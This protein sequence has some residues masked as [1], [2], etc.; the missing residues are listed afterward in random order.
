MTPFPYSMC[1]LEVQPYLS[2][3]AVKCVGFPEDD[4]SMLIRSVAGSETCDVIK[5]V[6]DTNFGCLL[7]VNINSNHKYS[8]VCCILLHS[9]GIL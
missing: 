9:Q 4:K 6:F 1:V 5:A 7:Y 8:F 2:S 3:S